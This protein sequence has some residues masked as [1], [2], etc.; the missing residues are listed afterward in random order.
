MAL[1]DK[2]RV[3]MEDF[4]KW[5]DNN[6]KKIPVDMDIRFVMENKRF[7]EQE[8]GFL[9]LKIPGKE[10]RHLLK[11]F[12]R[13]LYSFIEEELA[14]DRFQRLLEAEDNDELLK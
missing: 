12:Q 7:P 8:N 5:S 2:E 6:H 10:S 13:L 11:K 14:E 9:S 3:L 4:L 1:S